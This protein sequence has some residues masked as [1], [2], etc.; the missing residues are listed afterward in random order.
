MSDTIK[1]KPALAYHALTPL[2]DRVVTVFGIASRYRAVK[3]TSTPAPSP[4][5]ARYG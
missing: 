5:E 3:E 4:V 1:F 2:Y